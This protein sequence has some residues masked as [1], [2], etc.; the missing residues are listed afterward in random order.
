MTWTLIQTYSFNNTILISSQFNE[1]FTTL[2]ENTP[3]SENTLV[4]NGY[5]LSNPRMQAIKENSEFL[6]FT[7]NYEKSLSLYGSDYVE[8]YL[9]DLEGD[10]LDGNGTLDVFIER[11]HIGGQY[12]GDCHTWL[13]Q[14][15]REILHVDMY[16]GYPACSEFTTPS[17][18]N[19]TLCNLFHYFGN[20]QFGHNCL[21]VAHRCV[22][23]PE[24]T[25][26]LWFGH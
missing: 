24:S 5:R 26:Q 10:V 6:L 18:T 16:Y 1:I 11:G 15:A 17:I 4:W 12:F 19:Y 20:Y 13:A 23:S 22:E 3:I 9:P 7:C 25:T 14:N 2:Y 21:D 8:I